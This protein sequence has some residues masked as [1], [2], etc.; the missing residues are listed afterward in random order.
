MSGAFWNIFIG[1][2]ILNINNEYAQDYSCPQWAPFAFCSNG[3]KLLRQGGLPG[4]VRQ[5]AL[6]DSGKEKLM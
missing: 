3:E 2:F 1:I 6:L 4:V 5:V